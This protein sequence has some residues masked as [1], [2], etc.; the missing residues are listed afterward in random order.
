MIQKK[1][2]IADNIKEGSTREVE[3]KVDLAEW[4]GFK[5][6]RDNFTSHGKKVEM[7][8]HVRR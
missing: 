5:W 4:V 1:G 7:Y 3:F 8:E 6:N 2:F